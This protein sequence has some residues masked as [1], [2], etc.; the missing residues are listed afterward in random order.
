[1]PLPLLNKLNE[2]QF[3][4]LVPG[5]IREKV[6]W[7]LKALPKQVRRYVV[8]IPEFVTQFLEREDSKSGQGNS[9]LPSPPPLSQSLAEFI[10]A[11]TGA[12][13][14]PSIWREEMPPSHLLMNYR[15]VDDSGQELAMSRDLAQLKRQLGEAAQLIFFDT[16]PEQRA[17]IERDDVKRW[18]FGDLPEE[19]AF[20]R[21]GKKLTGYPALMNEEGNVSIRLFDTSATAQE[22]MRRGVRQ[23]LRSE[24]KEQMKQL[25]KEVYGQNKYIGQAIVQLHS[26]IKPDALR[27]DILSAI[28]DRAF[29]ADDALPRTEKDFMAL[30][31]RARARLPAV[32]EAVLRT[33]QS[34]AYEC[35]MLMGKLSSMPASGRSSPA[36]AGA[37]TIDSLKEQLTKQLNALVYPGFLS[38]TP[39]QQLQHLTRYL[40][41]MVVRLEKYAANPER[42][43]RHALVIAGL[44]QQYEQRLEKHVKTGVSDP[45]LA[46][47][48][49]QIEELRISLF[50]QELRTPYPVS[51]KRLQKLWEEVGA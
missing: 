35:H 47:F 6:T 33:A 21:A 7:Y 25:E 17:A 42:D 32:T 20:T 1:V 13:V 12:A 2:A 4:R 40:K 10:G 30:R 51:V 26:L 16:D 46:E 49:W 39:W 3:D 29:M 8:P 19:L 36:R 50:A 41:G 27:E 18:D 14:Q 34:I 37:M 28:A 43:M 9:P 31:Q 23:L 45:A 24:L 48:R 11:K 5:M 22:H 38:L 15:V 44:W